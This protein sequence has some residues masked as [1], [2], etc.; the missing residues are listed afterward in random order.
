MLD[1][2]MVYEH[3]SARRVLPADVTESQ[4][5]AVIEREP[6]HVDEIMAQTN[7]PV[8]VITA[9]LALM[10]LKGMVKQVGGMRYIA[11]RERTS[12]YQ[13]DAPDD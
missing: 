2:T 6:V 4:L 9:A 12:E 1:L 13:I 3:R 7:L 11:V 5:L 10:E 8:E